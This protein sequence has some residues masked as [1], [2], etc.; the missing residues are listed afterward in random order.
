M[1]VCVSIIDNYTVSHSKTESLSPA[2]KKTRP[3]AKCSNLQHNQS[4]KWI[5][6]DTYKRGETKNGFHHTLGAVRMERNVF[7]AMQAPTIFQRYMKWYLKEH[8]QILFG[9]CRLHNNIL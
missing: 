3:P 1:N 2:S 4:E 9:I 6:A 8:M 7:R 5:L